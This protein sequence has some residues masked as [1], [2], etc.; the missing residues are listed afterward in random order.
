[1]KH[2]IISIHTYGILNKKRKESFVSIELGKLEGHLEITPEQF[3]DYERKAW[4]KLDSL[5]RVHLGKGEL[6]V[7][8]GEDLDNGMTRIALLPKQKQLVLRG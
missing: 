5:C 3:N 1:M 2:T 8:H 6:K 4:D 7:F